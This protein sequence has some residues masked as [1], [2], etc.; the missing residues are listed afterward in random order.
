MPGALR[1]LELAH[2]EHGRLPWADLFAPAIELAENGFE[3]SPRLFGLLNGFKRF[4]RGDDFRSYFYDANGEPHP[5]G[6]RLKNPAVRRGAR[7]ARGAAA[8]SR[9]TRA[10]SRPP[11]PPRSATTTCGPGE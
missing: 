9:C 4:A 10:S 5:V 1:M 3:V 2:R 11:S 7:D 6:Y 8:R